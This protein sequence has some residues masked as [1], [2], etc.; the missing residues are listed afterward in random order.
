MPASGPPGRP[1]ARAGGLRLGVLL[2][3][4]WLGWG[5]RDAAA[6]NGTP[7]AN[8]PYG[9]RVTYVTPR[10]GS[11]R[12]GTLV[13]LIGQ[14]LLR[15]A[16]EDKDNPMMPKYIVRLIEPDGVEC[17]VLPQLSSSKKLVCRVQ[18]DGMAKYGEDLAGVMQGW[19]DRKGMGW[20]Q[21]TGWYSSAMRPQ[22]SVYLWIDGQGGWL[23]SA[24]NGGENAYCVRVDAWHCDHCMGMGSSPRIRRVEPAAVGPGEEITVTGNLCFADGWRKWSLGGGSGAGTKTMREEFVK[25]VSTGQ[26][27]ALGD[28]RTAA[29]EGVSYVEL[30]PGVRCELT[31]P[32]AKSGTARDYYPTS[33]T[34]Y[35]ALGLTGRDATA[36]EKYELRVLYNYHLAN[37]KKTGRWANEC[38]EVQFQCRVPD[39]APEGK[40]LPEMLTGQDKMPDF[41]SLAIRTR[42]GSGYS[43]PR[44]E[45]FNTASGPKQWVWQDDGA[46][47]MLQVT[48]VVHAVEIVA[49]RTLRIS[50]RF[51]RGST[52][53]LAETRAG[54]V[55]CPVTSFDPQ[56]TWV[57]C[58]VAGG[59]DVLTAI[60]ARRAKE[61]PADWQGVGITYDSG[62]DS[63][64]FDSLGGKFF[65]T[66][67][68]MVRERW[69]FRTHVEKN[70][71][72]LGD[73]YGGSTFWDNN[74]DAYRDTEGMVWGMRKMGYAV[75]DTLVMPELRHGS[76]EGSTYA[77]AVVD[78]HSS[79]M[80]YYS[81]YFLPQSSGLYRFPLQYD[82]L[83]KEAHEHSD[84]D[85]IS[86]KVNGQ[87]LAG[88]GRPDGSE[89]LAAQ[90]LLE[91]TR[92]TE[93]YNSYMQLQSHYK[94]AQSGTVSP[95]TELAAGSLNTVELFAAH[96]ANGHW[97]KYRG[98]LQVGVEQAWP[99]GQAPAALGMASPTV[100]YV[101][102][103]LNN[104]RTWT[105]S[106]A[107]ASG[108]TFT[109]GFDGG[110][111]TAALAHDAGGAAI[112]TA[113][114]SALAWGVCAPDSAD[115]TLSWGFATADEIREWGNGALDL[116]TA[117][118]GRGSVKIDQ[119][120]DRDAFVGIGRNLGSTSGSTG[121]G[122]A[123]LSFAYKVPPAAQAYLV[124]Q[125]R[126]ERNSNM[127][128]GWGIC[129]IVLNGVGF[130]PDNEWN[131]GRCDD[132][133]VTFVA[134]GQWHTVDINLY[135]LL[136][137]ARKLYAAFFRSPSSFYI[138]KG[139]GRNNNGAS[140][141]AEQRQKL[142]PIGTVHRLK[143][144]P[145]WIDALKFSATAGQGAVR[146]ATGA[147]KMVEGEA[148]VASVAVT[149][150]AS[151]L[152]TV[153]VQ[154]AA[155]CKAGEWRRGR[156]WGPVRRGLTTDPP[157]RRR[158][159]HGR[160]Y[161]GPGPHGGLLRHCG[162]VAPGPA[163]TDGGGDELVRQQPQ[164]GP[165]RQ[166]VPGRTG[167]GGRQRPGGRGGV[168]G[169][170]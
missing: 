101:E 87:R 30:G 57:E 74:Q 16:K 50:G 137:P 153:K 60:G 125:Y 46:P 53:T 63:N 84:K 76:V 134:D 82:T 77:G 10:Y 4:C 135:Q 28:I 168:E 131:Y 37:G 123:Y 149:R 160:G 165:V 73:G 40:Y 79:C 109:L 95:W 133:G 19:S 143:G 17:T 92:D 69:G 11:Y 144:G 140:L 89:I 94:R 5:V 116:S 147:P 31:K 38:P 3:A 27:D 14:G 45:W 93:V 106:L 161:G 152:V 7:S 68:G 124:I 112:Q 1:A 35:A 110:R 75:T 23:G 105:F 141:I 115:V 81:S 130:L 72:Y 8:C 157:T 42:D 43:F 155:G 70:Y 111:S 49:D 71:R 114:E 156:P 118:C 91:Y 142:P 85:R 145:F 99:L 13:T 97:S 148:A 54:A 56:G 170:D 136:G 122:S 34:K 24:W 48:A 12:G 119:S 126:D 108:G 121:V 80:M 26:T 52:V 39:S 44:T 151:D 21:G 18:K 88:Y 41:K 154:Q 127:R 22:G 159:G 33:F 65:T 2:L 163:D 66:A 98:R 100:H 58:T 162:R 62:T 32:G 61:S 29:L 138:E 107:P 36:G 158:G 9:F 150:D 117:Y 132:P 64:S 83:G 47:Y 96:W 164:P 78:M 129:G 146:T 113:L 166:V 51:L 20:R 128:T 167:H 25:M 102:A 169:R 90:A 120:L 139:P 15:D 86:V 67:P 103:K 55:A 59:E 104:P 6:C